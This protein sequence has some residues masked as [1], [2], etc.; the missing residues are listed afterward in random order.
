M[1]VPVSNS[2]EGFEFS[3]LDFRILEIS[4]GYKLIRGS[5]RTKFDVIDKNSLPVF[6]LTLESKQILS[7]RRYNDYLEDVNFSVICDDLKNLTIPWDLSKRDFQFGFICW[8]VFKFKSELVCLDLQIFIE[9]NWLWNLVFA[10]GIKFSN[11]CI[12]PLI[13][14]VLRVQ[15]FSSS[16]PANNEA[17][18]GRLAEIS[19]GCNILI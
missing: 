2:I 13:I 12:F 1:S 18:V 5:I 7:S 17:I 8:H 15:N 4:V 10:L 16:S 14:G 19:I 9:A 11:F 6:A 3:S